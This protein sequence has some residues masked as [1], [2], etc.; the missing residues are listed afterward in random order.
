MQ[1]K[2]E[3]LQQNIGEN[4]RK[5]LEIYKEENGGRLPDRIFIY[6][7]GVGEGQ[8]EEVFKVSCASS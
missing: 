8:I 3:E 4:I 6:R 7:D 2:N 1:E 5:S